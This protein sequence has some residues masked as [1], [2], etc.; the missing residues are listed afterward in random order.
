MKV[1]KV[2][3]VSVSVLMFFSF[4][5]IG[6]VHAQGDILSG[7]PVDDTGPA[8]HQT[9]GSNNQ[10]DTTQP[11]V[12]VPDRT[13]PLPPTV[14]DIDEHDTYVTGKTEGNADITIIKDG[15][16]IVPVKKAGLAGVFNVSIPR[17]LRG[18][19][20]SIY[21]IDA[22]GNKSQARIVTVQDLRAPE[23]PTVNPVD[24]NSTS[25]SGHTE[26]NAWIHVTANGELIGTQRA[27][28]VGT[29]KVG[30][31]TQNPGTLLNVY[32]IDNWGNLS[33]PAYVT[34]TDG[35]VPPS[36]SVNAV[37]DDSKY[38]SGKS[39]P[40]ARITIK[41]NGHQIAAGQTNRSGVYNISIS[42]QKAGTTLNVY[43]TFNGKTSTVK[44]LKISSNAS[45]P[46]RT[47]QVKIT[48]NRG[49]S[50]NIFLK[51][52]V[53]GDVIRAYNSKNHLLTTKTSGGSLL[54]ISIRQLGSKSGK[55]LLTITH[56]HMR[57]S[58]KSVISYSS[59]VSG[60]LSSSQIKIKNNKRHYD[61][62]TV[63]N[64]NK[65]DYIRVYNA[66]KKII[67]KK[68][69]K[70]SKVTFYIKQLGKSSGHVYITITHSHLRESGKK[71]VGFKREK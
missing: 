25:V 30:I 6:Q 52:L 24:S 11:P 46:L 32:A 50:D 18:T 7:Y 69:S 36:P 39:L 5:Q 67:A 54:T 34:V 56:P 4:A 60:T 2:L 19:V 37:N 71:S 16:Q 14:N 21:A 29:F 49:K 20:L 31:P 44:V 51:G 33:D 12:P 63:T 27:D 48:N 17:Q 61:S 13:A 35:T 10:G 55:L 43:A 9:D 65:G 41:A 53:K 45:K 57:T 28:I 38:V 40:N 62:I 59:E 66:K 70:S 68:T 64:I 22:A 26:S 3:F 8:N 23:I 1:W 42:K 15:R 47:S 58:G